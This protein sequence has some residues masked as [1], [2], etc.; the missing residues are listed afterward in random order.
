MSAMTQSS[1]GSVRPRRRWQGD[2]TSDWTGPWMGRHACRV[3]RAMVV[4]TF[5]STIAP[6]P[7]HLIFLYGGGVREGWQK[8]EVRKPKTE[9]SPKTE[10]RRPRT[11]GPPVFPAQRN[12]STG[13]R[14]NPTT[15]TLR[16]QWK[17]ASQE[18]GS[19]FG[20]QASDLLRFSV[21]GF[22]RLSIPGTPAI[23]GDA[24]DSFRPQNSCLTRQVGRCYKLPVEDDN[25]HAQP[26][27]IPVSPC[28]NESR[29]RACPPPPPAADP[30]PACHGAAVC[31]PFSRRERRTSEP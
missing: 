5:A 29:R 6:V 21:F 15:G 7:A 12:E 27:R 2:C 9:T 8:A 13:R 22:R 24:P 17:R 20:F 14:G 18:G 1:S 23:T 10:N 4:F 31:L 3:R 25:R 26:G 16:G 30:P 19:G 11:S 28:Y